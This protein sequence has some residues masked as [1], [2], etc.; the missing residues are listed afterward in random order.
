[1]RYAAIFFFAHLA[2]CGVLGFDFGDTSLHTM[3]SHELP[4]M[5]IGIGGLSGNP[6]IRFGK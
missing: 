3:F 6:P 2:F 4:S 1:M 5:H